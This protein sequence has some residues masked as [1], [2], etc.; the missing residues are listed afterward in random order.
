MCYN[1]YK[2]KN[3]EVEMG[4]F[5]RKKQ[6]VE[7]PIRTENV[8][9]E[10]HADTDT[11]TNETW[12]NIP[13]WIDADKEEVEIVSVIAAAVAAGNQ[14]ESELTVKKV[15]QRNPEVEL[16][17]VIAA[18]LTTVTVENELSIKSISKRRK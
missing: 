3:M 8:N 9:V 4:L 5:F 12:E 13:A 7:A 18:A 14:S 16:L 10:G 1:A 11:D 15:W 17:S 6:N 2:Y